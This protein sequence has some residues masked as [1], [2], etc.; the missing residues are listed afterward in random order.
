[1]FLNFFSLRKF[2]ARFNIIASLAKMLAVAWIIGL[3]LYFLIVKG[4]TENFR[5]PFA[6]STSPFSNPHAVISALFAG[7]FSYDG[8]D[9]LNFGA[10]EITHPKRNLPLSIIIGKSVMPESPVSI[11]AN[12]RHVH[13][14]HHLRGHQHSLLHRAHHPTVHFQPSR[15]RHICEGGPWV[16]VGLPYASYG[17][18]P[19]SG[20]P[21]R[22]YIRLFTLPARRC[23]RW[24]PTYVHQLHQS[25]DRLAQSSPCRACE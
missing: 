7:L 18:H 8:W 25:G 9:I 1:M 4:R 23:E 16:R 22:D 5:A 6:N 14:V 12:C 13:R 24:L 15:R 3:G 2:V 11:P 20:Q 19:A 17:M 10:E 21:Q